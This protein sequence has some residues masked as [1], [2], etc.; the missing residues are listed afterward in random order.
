MEAVAALA[1]ACN[2]MQ[3]VSLGVETVN[4]VREAYQSSSGLSKDNETLEQRTQAL[5]SLLQNLRVADNDANSSFQNK[6]RG[7]DTVLLHSSISKLTSDL[8]TKGEAKAQELK[9]VLDKLRLSAD[10]TRFTRK[11]KAAKTI[12]KQDNLKRLQDELVALQNDIEFRMVVD[13]R[14]TCQD[15]QAGMFGKLDDLRSEHKTI[16]WAIAE[17]MSKLEDIVKHEGEDTR[18]AIGRLETSF[19]RQQR[20]EQRKEL[21]ESFKFD[22]KFARQERI[23]PA[24]HNTYHWILD[25]AQA[26]SFDNFREWLQND[27]PLYWICGKVGSGKSTL[28]NYIWGY[29]KE[30]RVKLLSQW[31]ADKKL[32]T[33]AVFFWNPGSE[34]QKSLTGLLRSLIF[35]I[36][37]ECP[38]IVDDLPSEAIRPVS[39]A[40]PWNEGN[41]RELLYRLICLTHVR[42]CFFIDGLDEFGDGKFHSNDVLTDFLQSLLKKAS[43]TRTLKCCVSSRREKSFKDAFEAVPKLQME[44]VNTKDI[45][46]YVSQELGRFANYQVTAEVSDKAE[47]VF[48]WVRLAVQ[49]LKA[50]LAFDEDYPTLMRRLEEMPGEL[51]ELYAHMFAKVDKVHYEEVAWFLKIAA[52]NENFE[53]RLSLVH[54]T[55]GFFDK[56]LDSHRLLWTPARIN[57]LR[58][59]CEH[60]LKRV[61]YRSAGFIEMSHLPPGDLKF[62]YCAATRCDQTS[63]EAPDSEKVPKDIDFAVLPDRLAVDFYLR[64]SHITLTH[65]SVLEFLESGCFA[66]LDQVPLGSARRLY[67]KSCTAYLTLVRDGV[68]SCAHQ[69]CKA[70]FIRDVFE[71]AFCAE[72]VSEVADCRTLNILN[73]TAESIWGP[74]WVQRRDESDQ[75][76]YAYM[77]DLIYVDL[78]VWDQQSLFL[79]LCIWYELTHYVQETLPLLCMEASDKRQAVLNQ[80]LFIVSELCIGEGLYWSDEIISRRQ[81]RIMELLLDAGANPSEPILY[82][83]T[84][85]TLTS[86][87]KLIKAVAFLVLSPRNHGPSIKRFKKLQTSI[88]DTLAKFDKHEVDFR[89]SVPIAIAMSHL[90]KKERHVFVLTLTCPVKSVVAFHGQG[91]KKAV[92]PMDVSQMKIHHL[93]YMR[94]EFCHLL[95]HTEQNFEVSEEESHFLQDLLLRTL[96]HAPLSYTDTRGEGVPA[97]ISELQDIVDRR[98]LNEQ[99]PDAS[100][101]IFPSDTTAPKNF[102][103]DMELNVASWIEFLSI[104]KLSRML[105]AFMPDDGNNRNQRSQDGDK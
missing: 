60:M 99:C 79:S 52:F 81:V 31:A 22:N 80:T 1:L 56:Y 62:E 84:H 71:H 87:Q 10:D 21:I 103:N 51:Y 12:F 17:N 11:L 37:K 69:D 54:H 104:A 89:T 14:Q 29:R 63:N 34:M 50:G 86:W 90:H 64:R 67:V 88:D 53:R 16:V 47:G 91:N 38:E 74:R 7:K 98:N 59:D 57:T 97:C 46:K 68:F 33:A 20:L 65:R 76:V 13:I 72:A 70:R 77:H 40:N 9:T 3:I 4:F 102:M 100:K 6:D 95:P 49:N 27:Q 5:S 25:D 41:L 66:P 101:I 61:L 2:V 45:E 96:W 75:G 44:N 15:A 48:V 73:E 42:L 78:G 24:A 93:T 94:A 30:D 43:Q 32:V 105:Y 85:T 19:A 55:L 92:R 82:N 8:A 35:Q 83:A 23:H 36:L 39:V 18:L 58:G 28:M 26:S